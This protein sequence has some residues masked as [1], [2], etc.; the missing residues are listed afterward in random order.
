MFL[1][2]TNCK[3]RHDRRYEG[4]LKPKFVMHNLDPPSR[5]YNSPPTPTPLERSQFLI[6]FPDRGK[7]GIS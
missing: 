7:R 4:I 1:Y 2:V 6:F 5:K 3:V